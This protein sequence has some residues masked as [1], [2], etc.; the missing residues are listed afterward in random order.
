MTTLDLVFLVD[1]S[2]SIDAADWEIQKTGIAN[3]L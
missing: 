3:A 1:G 2:G